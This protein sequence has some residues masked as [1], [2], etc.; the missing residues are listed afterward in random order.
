MPVLTLA[1]FILETSL[2]N[3]ALI[4]ASDSKMAA[5]CLFMAL[6]MTHHIGWN[7]A[8]AFYSGTFCSPL[9]TQF[10]A[11]SGGLNR[12][13]PLLG[14]LILH[15]IWIR[16]ALFTKSKTQNLFRLR[17]QWFRCD[18][19]N[20]KCV[21]ARAACG[22]DETRDDS[23]KILPVCILQSRTSSIDDNRKINRKCR[24]TDINGS[25]GS[26]S[27]STNNDSTTC[28]PVD[29]WANTF[30]IS[31]ELLFVRMYSKRWHVPV[32]VP[33]TSGERAD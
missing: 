18:Y 8:L 11:S 13:G 28:H 29:C 5:A 17:I 31:V 9:S 19:T 30:S 15:F 20:D 10:A 3:Y 22:Y 16:F 27:S 21:F 4:N 12:F 2:M 26:S 14:F 23:Q 32:A 24:F 1:R 25:S 6:R 33:C 7:A